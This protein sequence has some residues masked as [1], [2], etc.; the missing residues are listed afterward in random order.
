MAWTGPWDGLDGVSARGADGETKGI[1]WEVPGIFP[2][3]V[4]K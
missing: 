4:G 2:S 1:Q 3:N